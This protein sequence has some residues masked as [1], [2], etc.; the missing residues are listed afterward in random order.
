MLD[1][2][3]MAETTPGPLIQVVQF[4]GFLGAYRNPGELS[5]VMAGV[6][7]RSSRPGPPTCRAS[8]CLRGRAV[9]ERLR[10]R[11]RADAALS[12]ITAAVVG[13]ILNLAV[14]FSVRTLFGATERPAWRVF[15]LELPVWSTV[16]PIAVAIALGA[17]LGLFVLK[18]GILETIA[19]SRRPSESR[20]GCCSERCQSCTSTQ[21]S[22]LYPASR[23]T[24]PAG[25]PAP[26]SALSRWRGWASPPHRSRC[27][28]R[29]LEAVR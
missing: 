2:L 4:V 5:P 27:G 28:I 26:T 25:N 6:W 14:W 1:G 20:C 23:G 29:R 3:G 21:R 19:A 8:S 15:D 7:G 17:G 16:D 11:K 10:G 22:S 13:V 18:R 9:I 24:S 12:A